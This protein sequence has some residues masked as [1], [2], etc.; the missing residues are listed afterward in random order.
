MYVCRNVETANKFKQIKG[1]KGKICFVPWKTEEQD[2]I[3]L[4]KLPG[5]KHFWE[6]V[7]NSIAVC[8]NGYQ[9]DVISIFNENKVYRFQE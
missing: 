5:Q 1:Y 2:L 9:V 3:Y 6:T 4:K 7:N 8:S